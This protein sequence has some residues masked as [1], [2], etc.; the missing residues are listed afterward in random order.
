MKRPAGLA[1]RVCRAILEQHLIDAG[2][3]VLTAVSGGPDSVA[4]LHLLHALSPRLGI[5]QLSVAHFNHRLR[6]P[7]ADGDAAFVAGLCRDLGL[8]CQVGTEDVAAYRERAGIS[9]EMAARECRQRFLLAAAATLGAQKIA[10]GHTANDQAE[11]VLLRLL[12]GTAPGGLSGMRPATA[13]GLVRPL[14]TLERSEILQ[15]LAEQGLPYRIDA[16]NLEPC[17]ERNRLRLQVLP[18]LREHFNPRLVQTLC[19]HAELAREEEAW[20]EHALDPRWRRLV[21]SEQNDRI[22]LRRR[23]LVAAPAPIGR[24]LLKRALMRLCGSFYGFR[25][26]HLEQLLELAASKRSTGCVHLPRNIRG[27]SEYDS[28][29]IAIEAPAE[30][31]PPALRIDAPGSFKAGDFTVTVTRCGGNEAA[32]WVTAEDDRFSAHLDQARLCWPLTL[33][34]WRPGDRFQPLG[35]RGSK[36]LQ[37]FFTDLKIPPRL[38]RRW[39]ILCDAEKI[40]WVVGCRLDERVKVRSSSAEAVHISIRSARSDFAIDRGLATAPITAADKSDRAR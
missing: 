27:R 35:M 25:R 6:G 26:V 23:S 7:A 13:E 29:T 30:E 21:R 28:F 20:W 8:D 12:R 15:Y 31:A 33:R 2:E 3:R 11:E 34:S 40:C 18:L 19:R 37:D 5:E 9:L 14:L 1:D 22:M 32:A 39:P 4:L 17:C 16:S 10:L 38:R 36:K 24:R